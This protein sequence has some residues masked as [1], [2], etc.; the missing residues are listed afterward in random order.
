MKNIRI[1]EKLQNWNMGSK[2]FLQCSHNA[3]QEYLI[4]QFMIPPSCLDRASFLNYISHCSPQSTA[5]NQFSHRQWCVTGNKVCRFSTG[6]RNAMRFLGQPT[7]SVMKHH[8]STMKGLK[9]Y[10]FLS[11]KFFKFVV[12]CAKIKKKNCNK[13]VTFQWEKFINSSTGYVLH[14]LTVRSSIKLSFLK[15]NK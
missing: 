3:S 12:V 4:G 5:V 2:I 1:S 14:R 7:P 8:I 15:G 6:H 9:Y 13:I 11:E 10:F